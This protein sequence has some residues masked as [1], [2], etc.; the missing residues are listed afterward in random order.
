MHAL[1]KISSRL[2]R[3]K[4]RRPDRNSHA[5]SQLSSD[6]LPSR[7]PNLVNPSML[8]TQRSSTLHPVRCCLPV[9]QMARCSRS[10]LP[11]SFGHRCMMLSSVSLK[12]CCV[13]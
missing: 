5:H 12:R 10:L 11:G 7:K 9:T 8:D 4:L 3:P 13:L 6:R 1:C 2:W